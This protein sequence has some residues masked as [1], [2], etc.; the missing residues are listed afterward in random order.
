MGKFVLA[1]KTVNMKST[2]QDGQ[3][4]SIFARVNLAGDANE[5]NNATAKLNVRAIGNQYT[6]VTMTRAT[7]LYLTL[8]TIRMRHAPLCLMLQS[9][10]SPVSL[11]MADLFPAR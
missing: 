3:A 6:D 4:G 10:H 5:S 7:M 8:P 9:P 11:M 2:P 1:I